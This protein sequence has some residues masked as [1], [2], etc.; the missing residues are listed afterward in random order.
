MPPSSS[1]TSPDPHPA[2]SRAWLSAWAPRVVGIGWGAL[3][4]EATVFRLAFVALYWSSFAA[5]SIADVLLS[6]AQGLRFDLSVIFALTG[7]PAI[8]LLVLGRTPLRVLAGWI[9]LTWIVV[10]VAALGV[11]AGIDLYYY[12]FVGRRVSFELWGM[13][14]EAKPIAGLMVAGYGLPTAVIS[15]GLLAWA[16]ATAIAMRRA[17]HRTA[18]RT[19]WITTIAQA[20]ALLVVTVLAIRGGTQTKP[21]SENMAFRSANMALGHLALNPAFTALK[22]LERR[23]VLLTYV[24]DAQ[25]N[26]DTRRLLGILDPPLAA[27]YPLLRRQTVSKV[28][29][30]R[31][32][33]ILTIESLSPQL[34]GAFGA[35]PAVSERFDALTREGLL[36]TDFYASGTRSLEGIPAILSG[37]PALPTQALLGSP[38]EQSGMASLARILSDDGYATLFEHGAFRG[39]MWFDQYAARTGFARYIAKEDFPDPD[40]QSDSTWGIFDH[41]ALERL[42]AELE[43]ARKPVFAFFFSLSSHTPYELPDPRFRKFPPTTPQADRLNS[44]AYTDWSIGR[45]FDLARAS[46]YWRDTVFVITGDHNVGGSGLTRQQAMHIPLLILVPGDPTFPRG[47]RSTTLGGQVDLAPT[48]LQ[49]LGLS[50]VHDFAGNSLLAPAA[51]RFVMFGLGGQAG[52]INEDSLVLHDLTRAV[53]LYRYRSDPALARNVLPELSHGGEPE[54]VRDLQSYLQATNNLLVRNRVFPAQPPKP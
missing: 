52:W 21:L 35:T 9:W 11:L 6:F 54:A 19:R 16:V 3:L 45:F 24:P 12:G 51:H 23:D 48:V 27:D 15:L 8:V 31:N 44:F 29:H 17:M 34:M 4:L 40:H 49:L 47:V 14:G 2:W 26:A 42:H 37:Y 7:L 13:L 25:A 53:A 32:L 1:P 10:L 20:I 41:I 39:S 50:S 43:A 30:P 46:S 33:V 36:F 18:P 28:A 5:D 38:L 22:A